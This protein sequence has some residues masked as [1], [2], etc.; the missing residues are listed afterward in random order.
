[1]S[2]VAGNLL[3]DDDTWDLY[4]ENGDLVVSSGYDAVRQAL[5]SRL[6]FFAGEWFAD[7]NIGIPYWDDV[8]IKKPNLPAIREIFRAQIAATPGVASVDSI[9]LA[10]SSGRSYSLSFVVTMDDGTLLESDSF[11]V[12][13]P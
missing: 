11:Q 4:L 2:S 6:R 12:G 3:L 5:Y 10:Q 13:A 7:E 9:S 8:L 1:M